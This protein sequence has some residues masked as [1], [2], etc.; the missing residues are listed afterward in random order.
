MLKKIYKNKYNSGVTLLELLIVI[1]IF[2]IITTT[3]IF[4]N[5]KLNSSFTTQNLADD[6]ALSVRKAQGYAIGV[7]KVGDS[8]ESGYGIH[9]TTTG[10]DE[11]EKHFGSNKSFILF[12]DLDDFKKY[13]YDDS[14][15]CISP[16]KDNECFESLSVK[17]PDSISNLYYNNDDIEISSEGSLDI[18]F[19][20]ILFQRYKYYG[21]L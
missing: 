6:I 11:N 4:N 9:F 10:F 15:N 2:L 19:K 16:T 8:F 14:V 17:T 7:R 18:I 5:G 20:S 21:S 12:A 13:N 1:S 3:I